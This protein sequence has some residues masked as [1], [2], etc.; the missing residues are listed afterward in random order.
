MVFTHFT[1]CVGKWLVTAHHLD[2]V[3]E[4]I[5]TLTVTKL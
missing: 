1:T 3:V 5:Y 4:V 2:K